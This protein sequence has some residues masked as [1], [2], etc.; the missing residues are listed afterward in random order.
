ML[1]AELLSRF[2]CA[3]VPL[4]VKGEPVIALSGQ[5]TAGRSGPI[6]CRDGNAISIAVYSSGPGAS[7]DL[8]VLGAPAA[9]STF[10]LLDD[11]A[12]TR[13]IL[14]SQIFYV[15]AASPFIV[16]DLANVVGSF[17]VRVTPWFAPSPISVQAV[18]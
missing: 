3:P 6:D 17:T 18:I 5:A 10:L 14:Y 16:I 13:R 9:D 8:S 12:A 15:L 2:P 1:P 11:P 7:C 4:R